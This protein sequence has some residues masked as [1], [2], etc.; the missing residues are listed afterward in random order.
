VRWMEVSTPDRRKRIRKPSC[1]RQMAM[2]LL[3]RRQECREVSADQG[4]EANPISDVFPPWL[5]PDPLQ[6]P[7]GCEDVFL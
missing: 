2:L 3:A 7:L 6:D 4:F 1:P 5:V